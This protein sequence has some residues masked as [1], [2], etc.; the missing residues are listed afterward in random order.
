MTPST[1]T[2]ASV[3]I[4]NALTAVTRA[5]RFPGNVAANV[6]GKEAPKTQDLIP[7]NQALSAALVGINL[8]V[9]AERKANLL[10]TNETTGGT[11]RLIGQIAVV[12]L[13]GPV[14]LNEET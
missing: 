3:G 5:L 2:N 12:S 14:V 10:V 7:L 11:E 1:A 13:N 6:A 8:V 4:S 9:A